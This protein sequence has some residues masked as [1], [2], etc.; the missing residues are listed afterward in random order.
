LPRRKR[1]N[2][3]AEQP[4]IG[5]PPTYELVTVTITAVHVPKEVRGGKPFMALEGMTESGIPWHFRMYLTEKARRILIW[6]LRKA[7]YPA[8][9]IE[10]ELKLKKSKLVGCRLKILFEEREDRNWLSP[11][12]FARVGETDLEE[13]LAQLT[14][15]P[16]DIN[17]DMEEEGNL[18]W[19]D[20]L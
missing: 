18:A 15:K 14:V 1:A 6:F 10:P 12:G 3:H 4:A 5:T 9:L 11:I 13:R 2:A 17:A 8:E 7:E 16:I 20:S 19:L